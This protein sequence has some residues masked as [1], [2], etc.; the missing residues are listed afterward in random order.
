MPAET[1]GN[2]G[3]HMILSDMGASGGFEK[4]DIERIYGQPFIDGN[5]LE[6]LWRGAKA[7]KA[8]TAAVR[9]ARETICLQFYIYRNDETGTALA[10]LL[11]QK[12]AEGV[13]VYLL[14]DHLGSILTPRKF[15]KSLREAG[16]KVRPSHPFLWLSPRMYLR[17]DHRKLITIDGESAFTG[18]L[19]IANEYWGRIIKGK[20]TWRDTGLLIHGPAAADLTSR[21]FK[22]WG[23]LCR[24]PV[25]YEQKDFPQRGNLPVLPIFASSGKGRRMMRKL[26]Y[27]S[28]NQAKNDICLTT[29]YFIPSRQM[30]HTLG[31]AVKRGARVRL[32]VPMVSD[33]MAAHYAARHF[34]KRLLRAGVEVYVYKGRMLHAKT[35][36]FDGQ[37]TVVGSANLDFR[38]LRKNDEGN[39]GILDCTFAAEMLSLFDNDLKDSDRITMDQWPYR[40]LREKILERFF[41]LFRRRL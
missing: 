23:R 18:G 3:P 6:L 33:V 8:I 32:L 29:A 31:A 21:F 26:L 40:P 7:F 11:K 19:N 15:W 24:L 16:I 20:K 36:V 5:R 22:A 4:Q 12:A 14:Y 10:E 38:S 39:V 41:S 13:E 9:A 2:T 30:M 35:Y 34:F 27:F 1:Q 25:S 28:I 17:R 37:W